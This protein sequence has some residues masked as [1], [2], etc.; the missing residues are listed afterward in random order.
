MTVRTAT[1]DD[2]TG[3]GVTS[4]AAGQPDGARA[5][6]VRL[7]LD[8]ATVLVANDDA[9]TVAGWGAVRDCPLGSILTDLFVA[10]DRHGRG[11][12]GALLRRLWPDQDV[13][14][15]FTFASQHANALPLYARAGL[16]PGWLLLYL[17]GTATDVPRSSL[18]T[19]E[20]SA[21][22][23]ACA[24][25]ELAG[26][27]RARDYAFWASTATPIVLHDGARL[28]GAGVARRDGLVHLTCADP[29]VATESLLA[30]LG[31]CGP[32]VS[33]CVPGPHPAVIP[34]L[35]NGFRVVDY[36]IAMSTPDVA[37]PTSWAYSPALA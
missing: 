22:A 6:Y 12:G 24:D 5:D 35:R 29:A 3:I 10:P 33:V 25:A 7:L 14:G 15:R 16:Q 28:V 27:D 26:G 13:G 31:G 37:L 36:D 1:A 9:R 21:D 19:T 11:V 2:I 34:L 4:L 30:A 17:R 18:A 8:T 23:A 32:E 20:V